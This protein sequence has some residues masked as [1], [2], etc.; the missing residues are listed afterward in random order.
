MAFLL[1]AIQLFLASG[2]WVR[3]FSKR[4][5]SFACELQPRSSLCGGETCLPDAVPAELRKTVAPWPERLIGAEVRSTAMA[6][7]R[8]ES[9]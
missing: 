4:F 8:W 9:G 3:R 2:A 7:K 5:M 1:L 6:N